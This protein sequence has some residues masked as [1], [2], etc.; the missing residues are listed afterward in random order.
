MRLRAVVNQTRPQ[1]GFVADVLDVHLGQG[2]GLLRL[3]SPVGRKNAFRL[4]RLPVYPKRRRMWRIV[5][6]ERTR[7]SSCHR[8]QGKPF[9]SLTCAFS[10]FPDLGLDVRLGFG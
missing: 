8:C 10:R 1:G 5:W 6:G 2:E 9:P 4:F 7:P 3:P